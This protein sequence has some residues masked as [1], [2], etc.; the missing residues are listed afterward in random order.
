[1]LTK[2]ERDLLAQSVTALRRD[3][4]AWEAIAPLAELSRSGTEVSID[5]EAEAQVGAPV[6]VAS[7]RPT[8]PPTLTGRQQE[9]CALLARGL[10][11]KEIARALEISPATVKDHVQAILAALDLK[12]RAEVA[13]YLHRSQV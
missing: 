9:V 13:G 10:T 8:P 1:M 7:R 4:A 6:I 12:S 3:G 5:L 11:N 2:S